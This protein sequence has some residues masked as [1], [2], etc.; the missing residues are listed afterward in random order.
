MR[1][2]KLS[3]S[4]FAAFLLTLPSF[5]FAQAIL[6]ISTPEQ[7]ASFTLEELLEMPQT[8]VVTKNDYVDH[9]AAFQGPLLR[10]ILETFEIDRHADLNMI[11]LNDF[12][13]TVPAADAFDYDVILAVLRDGEGMTVRNKGPIWVIY[14]MDEHPELRDDAYNN[15]LV[16]QLKEISVE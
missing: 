12:N 3:G 10:A 6:T 8:T 5:G 4:A 14:P 1:M 13:S 16:W 2:Q 9:P 15:R 11:A 7:S